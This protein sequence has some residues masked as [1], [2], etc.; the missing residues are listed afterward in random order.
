[1]DHIHVPSLEVGERTPRDIAGAFARLITS[2][3]LAPGDRLPTVRVV[4]ADLGVSP[5]TVSGAWQA[6][7][8]TGMIVSRGRAGSFV[9]DE[10]PPDRLSPRVQGLVGDVGD[11]PL[12]LS[13]GTPDPA[14]LPALA[15]ALR[16]V[17]PQ[18]GTGVY[19]ESPVLPELAEALRQDWPAPAAGLTVTDG[20]MD[21]IARV[22]DLTVR[23]GDVVAVES[24]TF[25][26]FLDLLDLLGVQ[27]VPMGMDREGIRPDELDRALRRGPRVV[28]LQPRAHNPTGA[29]MTTTRAE[30]LARVLVDH[31]PRGPLV[32]EDDHSS[33]TSGSP[34][35]TLARFVPERV[36]HVR[37]FSKSLGPDLRIAGLSGPADL[38]DRVVARRM[39]GPGW[40]SRLVQRIAL[41]LM[42]SVESIEQVADARR[43]YA[44]RQARLRAGLADHGIDLPPHDGINAWVPVADER[45]A[46]LHLAASGIR[47]AGGAP[48]VTA[49]WSGGA[50]LRVTVG[51]L[52]DRFEHVAARLAEASIARG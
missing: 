32:I 12:D 49:G 5:A 20:A 18:A 8:R 48:F 40:T 27:A 43:I 25:P 7:R 30:E 14:L 15:P 19:Q 10:R 17:F 50:H 45:A 6:L 1:M 41:D 42:T 24:P 4:A 47:V 34:D 37:S 28:L 51:V 52:A 26:P 23:F 46:L 38:I 16:R 44:G 39:L 11:Q 3:E 35:V 29:S 33:Q 13:R 21:A 9:R 31:G 36:A 2:G 22:L